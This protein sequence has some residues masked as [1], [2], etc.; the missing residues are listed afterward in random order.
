MTSLDARNVSV[1]PWTFPL[2]MASVI[3]VREPMSLPA[4]PAAAHRASYQNCLIEQ[5]ARRAGCGVCPHIKLPLASGTVTVYVS[6]A[7]EKPVSP[8]W[9][10]GAYLDV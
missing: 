5:L 9:I 8:S 4:F 2:R 7:A 10:R 1:L 3:G 6:R